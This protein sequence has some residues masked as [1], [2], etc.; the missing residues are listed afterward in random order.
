[1]N[2]QP[3][4]TIYFLRTGIDDQNKVVCKTQSELFNTLTNSNFLRGRSESD[5][6]QKADG[7][8][9]IRINH[10]A[11][12]YYNLLNCDTIMYLNQ[13][14]PRAFYIVGNILSV[15][16]KNP[17]CSFVTFKLDH[18]MTF[19]TMIDWDKTYAYIEREHIKND[20]SGAG[21]P[22]FTN[23]GPVEDFTVNPDTPFYHFEKTFSPDFVMVQSPY[24]SE[25][26]PVF[27]GDKIG[28]L[29]SSL[30]T[31]IV[32]P[33]GANEFFE[34]IA[35]KTEASINNIVGVYG[36]PQDFHDAIE[37][38]DPVTWQEELPPV[39][40]A[41]MTNFPLEYNNAKC[42][43]APYCIIK[44]FSSEG[45]EM[46]FTPQWFGNDIDEYKFKTKY[47]GAGKQFGGAMAAFDNS[48]GCFDWNN[49]ADWS[50][51]LTQLPRCP[52]TADGFREWQSINNPAIMGRYIN[53]GIKLATGL[54][55]AFAQGLGNGSEGSGDAFGGLINGFNTIGNFAASIGN[56]TATTNGA[57]A[58]GTTVEGT[59]SFGSLFDIGQ[60]GW[61]FKVVYL[62]AQNYIM[63]SID[64]YFDR[65][66]YRVNKLKKLELENRPIWTFIKTAECH[67]AVGQGVP[68][69]SEKAINAMF[70][71]GVTMWKRDKYV[72]GRA[73]GDF[74][75][76]QENKGVS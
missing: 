34:V 49:W 12:D 22:L 42:W 70:N 37:R 56:I 25:G 60:G 62:T 1:M 29:Y 67:V 4:T 2:F 20:W 3:E 61:G 39:E 26:E 16:W 53:S 54:G 57:Q 52:W 69:I 17:D 44:L 31:N 32:G 75:N 50:V 15:E 23:I 6:F 5:S 24:D 59:G 46:T 13:G 21:H 66:G 14:T 18:F 74:S 51:M 27:D 28:N 47:V 19:Q 35:E 38:G 71:R 36:V 8:Y 73:I 64:Q 76:A 72:A 7:G 30:Q 55:S 9:V 33:N 63:R 40:Q 10:E 58:S 45:S 65:F 43:A 48:G 41:N 11:I 68:Y